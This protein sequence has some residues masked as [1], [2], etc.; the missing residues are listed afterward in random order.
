MARIINWRVRLRRPRRPRRSD[1]RPQR[2]R[3]HPEMVGRHER[4]ELLDLVEET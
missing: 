1:G 3:D 2:A 4:E